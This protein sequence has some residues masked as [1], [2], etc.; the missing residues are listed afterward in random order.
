MSESDIRRV[1]G[2]AGQL[3]VQVQGD[4]GA[5]VVFMTH[6][7]LSDRTMWDE[8][9]ALLVAQGFRVVRADTRG[10]GESDAPD[11]PDGPCTMA[12][13]VADSVAVLDALGIAS[14]HYVGL[15][16]GGMSGFGLGLHHAHRLLSLCLCDARA[17]MPAAAAAVWPER[18]ATARQQGCAALAAS[19]VERWF[20]KAFVDANPATAQRF[21]N[22]ASATSAAGFIGCAEAIIG[23][24]Y[25]PRVG[26]IKTRTALIVGADDGPL[27]QALRDLQG[28]MAGAT[29]DVIAGAGHLP[30][31]DQPAAFNA[32]LLRHLRHL[33][34]TTGASA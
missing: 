11:K 12:D 30:N 20:G 5:P 4:S 3:A 23:L 24:D 8:Q 17:D 16:L 15:S 33:H 31:I 14:A 34:S 7:I 21:L 13:L 2:P 18:I 9:A 10:H 28:L 6:S 26:E 27:P 29:L 25:L 1:P 32:A 22:S 19:T